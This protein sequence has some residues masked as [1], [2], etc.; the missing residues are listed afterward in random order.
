ML[1]PQ[2]NT[3][4]RQIMSTK[5]VNKKQNKKELWKARIKAWETSGLSKSDFCKEQHIPHSSFWKWY[6]RLSE[7]FK[8][9]ARDISFVPIK[10]KKE[11]IESNSPL[12][13]LLNGNIKIAIPNDVDMSTL[14]ILLEVL[15]VLSC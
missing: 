11:K 15:G 9:E 2:L 13:I 3:L 4:W 8:K 7:K 14:K 1:V 5:I 12:L 6:K 10:I